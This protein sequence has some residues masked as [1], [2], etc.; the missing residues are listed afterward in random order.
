LKSFQEIKSPGKTADI[1]VQLGA[2][3]LE[4]GNAGKSL[5]C[6]R[7]IVALLA[8]TGLDPERNDE[9]V[10]FRSKLREAGVLKEPAGI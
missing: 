8:N 3:S 9:Y 6:Y 5:D 1:L 2:M 10:L 7:Q 4:A